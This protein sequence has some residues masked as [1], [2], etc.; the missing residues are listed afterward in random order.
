MQTGLLS[1]DEGDGGADEGER[2]DI[3]L[4]DEQNH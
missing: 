4:W 1:A 3:L 2:E